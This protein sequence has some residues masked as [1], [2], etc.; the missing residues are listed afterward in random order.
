MGFLEHG[1]EGEPD[2][3]DWKE[4]RVATTIIKMIERGNSNASPLTP[5]QIIEMIKDKFDL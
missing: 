4:K 3:S 5:N 1:I 2:N